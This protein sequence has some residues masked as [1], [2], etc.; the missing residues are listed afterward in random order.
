M[1]YQCLKQCGTIL[2]AARGS[3]IDS[4]S[5]EDRSLLSTWKIPSNQQSNI[6]QNSGTSANPTSQNSESMDIALNS[7][8][9]PAKRRKL[10]NAENSQK[11]SE[12]RKA[13]NR[14]DAVAYGLQAPAVI[15][16]AATK[17]GRHVIAVTGEDKSIRV[18]E[19]IFEDG[20][21]HKLRQ[22]SQRIMP[23]R[24][25]ALAILDDDSTI[26]AG[27]K[28]G[29]VY[30]LPLLFSDNEDHAVVN[31]PIEITKPGTSNPFVPAANELTIHSQR[32]RKALENQ[33][34]QTNTPAEK[35]GP[36]FEHTLL[37]GHVSMLTDVALA[38]L[39]GRKYIITADRDEHIRVSRGIPQAHI[40]EGFCLGHTEFVSRLCIPN[41]RPE[42]LVSAGGDTD[43][44]IW[45][46]F[47]GQLLSSADLK[48]HVDEVI[49]GL[50]VKNNLDGSIEQ[51]KVAV[52]G[53]SHLRLV[54]NDVSKD[55]IIV[56]CESV[57]GLFIFQL[58]S[59]HT[60]EHTQTVKLPGNSLSAIAYNLNTASGLVVSIDNINKPGTTTEARDPSDSQESVSLLLSYTFRNHQAIAEDTFEPMNNED[61]R[62][63]SNTSGMLGNL[64]YNLE[65]LRKREGD[66][67]EED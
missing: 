54:E 55:L 47:S 23:K 62:N 46:W 60:L 42:I 45:E 2:I 19:N 36:T 49:G 17:G 26:I 30:S 39:H 51:T 66:T 48:S 59:N 12:K 9:P 13:N 57:P 50:K 33:R 43:I 18:L 63:N 7:E 29:D 67:K 27:D 31:S 38:T 24:P 65:N 25:C 15:A 52:S 14:S 53:I 56:L 22:I 6:V 16:L 4:F 28:F 44:F 35:I 20:G 58:G 40:I 3:S 21:T 32:N 61:E 41:E 1:P 11:P 5:L 64:L 34:R 8:A 10:S 37:L